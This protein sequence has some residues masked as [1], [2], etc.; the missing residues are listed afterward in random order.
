MNFTAHFLNEPAPWYVVQCKPHK[1]RY[2]VR[3]LRALLG[4][5]VFVPE[6]KIRSRGEVKYVPLFPGYFFVQ[7]DLRKVARSRINS[8]PGVLRLIEFGGVPQVV[9]PFVMEVIFEEVNRYNNSSPLPSHEL[10]PGDLVRVKD[11]PLQE[12][13]MIFVGGQTA[14]QRVRVLF[15][16]L[17]RMKEVQIEAELLEKITTAQIP[18]APAR[19]RYTRGKGRRV[20]HL[21]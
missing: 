14:N 4:L 3:A 19:K 2:A 17:G 7:V 15:E 11:G 20:N 1:E 21:A 10:Q 12:L 9:P 18:P 16:F 8:S 13:K 6:M 5:T